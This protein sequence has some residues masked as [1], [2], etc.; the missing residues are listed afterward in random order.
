[1]RTHPTILFTV[2]AAATAAAQS[3]DIGSRRELFLDHYLIEKL[4]AAKL[5][6]QKPVDR[7]A[8]L[9]YDKPWEGAFSAY[10]TIIHDGP[11]YRFYYRGLPVAKTELKSGTVTCYAE[12]SDGIRWTK[13]ELGLV[14]V[15]GSK[16]NNVI[17]ADPAFSSDFSP[18]LDTRPGVAA[19]ERYKALA[20][21]MRTGLVAFVSA[22]G[23]RW[24]KLREEP[25]FP[26]TK[27]PS[28]DS[29][30]LAFWSESER[31][32]VAYY[33]TFKS[34]PGLGR[35]RWITRS[36]SEDFLHWTTPQEMSFG[37]APPE[38]LYVNQTGPY[39]RAPHIYVSIAAR[40]WP[41]RRALS[42]EEIQQAG[43][44][45]G[46]Y[47]D[48]SDAVFFTSRGG[49]RYDR[50]FLESFVRPGLGPNHWASRT[51]YPILNVVQTSPA[52]ISVYINR[53][54]AQ[55]TAQV[56]RYTLRLDGFA[57]VHAPYAGG[58]MITRPFT[59]QGKQLEINYSTSAA[60]FI[61]VE[62]QDASGQPV[63]GYTL[64]DAVEIVGDHLARKVT[65][66]PG[67]DL[68]VLAGKAVRLRF[69]MKDADLYSMRFHE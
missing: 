65:W 40:F 3:I 30:N 11:R 56:H 42:E 41:G 39:F 18:F 36:T 44:L 66:K 13:P 26:A 61:R 38:H 19:A 10:G 49:T 35:V 59:F 16:R 6:M 69:A 55:P 9:K 2:L 25:V 22:D 54:Y 1:M 48:I 67:S 37:D 8:V 60:G 31:Q 7:G 57:A 20:G 4:N 45:E 52:E 21:T 53:N 58:E 51:N 14:E 17:L 28:F 63:A 46:Y 33:R 62:L 24:R 15:G 50:T 34:F 64:A 68:F 43:I 47:K 5:E 29:Q 27:Q 32:Y 23:I 12:S